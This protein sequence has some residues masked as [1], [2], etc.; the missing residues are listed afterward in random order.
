[1][2]GQYTTD[3]LTI[4]RNVRLTKDAKHFPKT[5]DK[6]AVTYVTFVDGTKNGEDIFV[7]AA[8]KRGADLMSALKKGDIV[9]VTGCVEFSL[10]TYNGKMQGKIFDASVATQVKLKDRAAEGTPTPSAESGGGLTGVTSDTDGSPA[11][12]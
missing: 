9:S 11:F 5:A 7:D 8:I 2:A 12:D 10:S 4:Y 3:K 6:G 1:M